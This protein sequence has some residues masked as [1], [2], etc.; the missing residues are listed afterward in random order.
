VR[1]LAD[2]PAHAEAKR[3]IAKRLDD[4]LVATADPR[5]D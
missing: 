1:S 3:A 2:D 5:A 4:Y